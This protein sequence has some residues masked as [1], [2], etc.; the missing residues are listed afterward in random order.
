M[1]NKKLKLTFVGIGFCLLIAI[2]FIIMMFRSQSAMFS[3]PKEIT[4]NPANW[5]GTFLVLTGTVTGL[6]AGFITGNAVDKKTMLKTNNETGETE[7]TT[8]T[9]FTEGKENEKI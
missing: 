1:K 8:V 9:G 7:L 3:N 2:P 5:A 6:I 4:F